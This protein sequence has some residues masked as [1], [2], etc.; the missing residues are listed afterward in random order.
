VTNLAG[1]GAN[2]MIERTFTLSNPTGLHARPAALFV[3]TAQ[4]FAGTEVSVENGPRK[5]SARSLLSVLA[6]GAGAGSVITVRCTG[7]RE[8]EALE[9]LGALIESRFGE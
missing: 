5:A 7:P 2:S 3:Q 1:K 6:L 8:A 9:A 4:R